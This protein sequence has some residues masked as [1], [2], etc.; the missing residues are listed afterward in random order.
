M[1]P[2]VS[3][4]CCDK[5]FDELKN[6]LVILVEYHH[7]VVQS[8][9]VFYP[10]K[11]IGFHNFLPELIASWLSSMFLKIEFLP[12]NGNFSNFIFWI[13]FYVAYVISITV[14][15]R[16]RWTLVLFILDKD[17]WGIVSFIYFLNFYFC[18][19]NN[20]KLLLLFFKVKLIVCYSCWQP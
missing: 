2:F 13:N 5:F 14:Y 7:C 3:V 18:Y 12:I 4:K 19:H 10:K 15:F 11:F 20:L 16:F 6:K 8:E 9:K 17:N 1:S